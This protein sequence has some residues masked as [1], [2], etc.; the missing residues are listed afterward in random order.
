MSLF[1]NLTLP[2]LWAFMKAML[3]FKGL[4]R[5]TYNVSTF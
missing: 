3:M 5:L 2:L 1:K 4:E